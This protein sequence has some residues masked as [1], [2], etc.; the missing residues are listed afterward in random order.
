MQSDTYIDDNDYELRQEYALGL[1]G[2][3]EVTQ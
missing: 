1:F 2:G 3:V